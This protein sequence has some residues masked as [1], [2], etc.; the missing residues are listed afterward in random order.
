MVAFSSGS[1]LSDM[2]GMFRLA[3]NSKIRS[4]AT[5]TTAAEAATTTT[6]TTAAAIYHGTRL[7]LNF[8][9]SLRVR[10]DGRQEN[11]GSGVFVELGQ[12]RLGL[13]GPG[14]IL[15]YS[16]SGTNHGN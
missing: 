3:K 7:T 13:V 4:T 11:F 6:T 12:V 15:C 2:S 10:S 8:R 5:T 14:S 16:K 9:R 1:R